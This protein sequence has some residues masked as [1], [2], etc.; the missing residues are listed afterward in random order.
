MT[1]PRCVSLDFR[2]RIN[3]EPVVRGSSDVLC[4]L[5]E[6]NTRGSLVSGL[7]LGSTLVSMGNTSAT[8]VELRESSL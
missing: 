7:V 3:E 5:K 8:W 6:L 4:D 2:S 1:T